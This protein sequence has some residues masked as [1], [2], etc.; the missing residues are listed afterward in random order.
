MLVC[1]A[2]MSTSLLVTKMKKHAEAKGLE[3]NIWAS[4]EA[5]A[6]STW[7]KADIILLGPQVRFLESKIKKMVDDKIPVTVIDMVSYVA[8]NGQ[9]VLDAALVKILEASKNKEI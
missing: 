3:V 1:S 5:D 2:G 9:K 8:M 4:A 6:K 7:V